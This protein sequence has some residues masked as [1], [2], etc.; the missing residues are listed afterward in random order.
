MTARLAYYAEVRIATSPSTTGL[1][2]AGAT[3]IIGGISNGPDG[4][5]YAVLVNDEAYMISAAD[6]TPTGRQFTREDLYD[7]SSI[8]VP[9]ERYDS[10]PEA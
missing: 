4:E 10:A 1:G 5:I 9:P 3:G 7:G 2:V 6:L 8:S